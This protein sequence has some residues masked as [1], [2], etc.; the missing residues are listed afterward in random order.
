MFFINIPWT[1]FG[2]Y[3]VNPAFIFDQNVLTLVKVTQKII[4][5]MLLYSSVTPINNAKPTN[6]KSLSKIYRFF[7]SKYKEERLALISY[8]ILRLTNSGIGIVMQNLIVEQ[9]KT[10]FT[11]SLINIKDGWPISKASS[12]V[13]SEL[14]YDCANII[15]LESRML[16][17]V[18][19]LIVFLSYLFFATFSS[20]IANK[21]FDMTF[22]DTLTKPLNKKMLNYFE[23]VSFEKI[24]T[25]SHRYHQNKSPTTTMDAVNN[26]GPLFTEVF[27]EK[28]I[29]IF[30]DVAEILIRQLVV[31]IYEQH[32]SI[33]LSF[34]IVSTALYFS[35]P[36]IFNDVYN[37]SSAY[38]EAL[39]SLNN[40]AGDTIRN[41]LL[42]AHTANRQLEEERYNM[43]RENVRRAMISLHKNS[44]IAKFEI[45]QYSLIYAML[46][47]LF[48]LCFG[49]LKDLGK[50]IAQILN[51][52]R[53]YQPIFQQNSRTNE[54][55]FIDIISTSTMF[56]N[57]FICIKGVISILAK[58]VNMNIDIELIN[59]YVETIFD[60]DK[61]PQDIYYPQ[62]VANGKNQ[63]ITIQLPEGYGYKGFY[64]E[65][66]ESIQR[67]IMQ[68]L[69]NAK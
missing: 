2:F 39:T 52:Y 40:N 26:I 13:V 4:K 10:P 11:K 62:F 41:T 36:R 8:I 65:K 33:L 19:V 60:P 56:I 55:N 31:A 50:E 17:A 16:K 14:F 37:S 12:G 25:K 57:D 28:M 38:Q 30:L 46:H 69:K 22:G 32:W 9:I 29:P 66:K 18:V 58:I 45:L 1:F 23:I 54:D 43:A 24:I 15:H 44:E 6:R 67:K 47:I 35:I 21:F 53:I 48:H 64:D 27:Q 5:I 59:Q 49:Q 68:E 51:L 42:I 63:G 34:G 3:V 61:L 7:W 20:K